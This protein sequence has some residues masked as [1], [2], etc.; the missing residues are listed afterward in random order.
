MFQDTRP[1][2]LDGASGLDAWAEF[3]VTQPQERARLLRQ[4]CDGQ[5]PVN[6]NAPDGTALTVTLWAVDAAQG[7]IN[8]SAEPGLPQLAR[9]VDADEAVA[10]AYLESIKLQ[11]DLHG[12]MLVRGTSSNALQCG[13]PREIYRFQRRNAYRV[14]PRGAHEPVA[15]LRH[16][17]LPDMPLALRV[18]DVSIGGCALWLP[19][20]VPPLQAGTRVGEMQ[21]ELDADT[22]FTAAMTLQHVSGQGHAEAGARLG[23]E[24]HQL[25]AT[26]ERLLQRWIDRTQ[27]RRRLLALD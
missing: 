27:Q 24:W 20:D 26:A 14:R 7:R 23:C 8:L 19:H 18:L 13:L 1:A 25:P 5:V 16:P 17:A 22:R 6:L 3:R 2:E 9:I 10:V 12:F 21:L 15:R 11:F 4:L